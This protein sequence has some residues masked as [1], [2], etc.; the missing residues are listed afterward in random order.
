MVGK[1][2]AEVGSE[3]GGL[4]MGDEALVFLLRERITYVMLM[5]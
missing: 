5:D 2:M 1:G 4:G 3:V